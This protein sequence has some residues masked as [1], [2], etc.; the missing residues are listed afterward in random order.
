MIRLALV[1]VLLLA[2]CSSYPRVPEPQNPVLTGTAR[3]GEPVG[4]CFDGPPRARI[5]V[6]CAA[7]LTPAR[8][9][10]LQRALA[11]RGLFEGPA[12]GRNGPATGEAVR[13]YQARFGRNDPRLTW[14]AAE[15]LGIVEIAPSVRTD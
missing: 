8:V 6:L 13:K 2:G 3:T 4:Q 1:L 15:A 5:R 12:N 7:D 11:A 10:E 9:T 14:P